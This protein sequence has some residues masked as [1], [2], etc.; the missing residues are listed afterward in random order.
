MFVRLFGFL[1]ASSNTKAPPLKKKTTAWWKSKWSI[2]QNKFFFDGN[3]F[4]IIMSIVLRHPRWFLFPA[5]LMYGL[6]VVVWKWQAISSQHFFCV[7]SVRAKHMINLDSIMK[8][9]WGYNENS[10]CISV[11]F[12]RE[13]KVQGNA[14]YLQS[15][16]LNR[17]GLLKPYMKSVWC[18]VWDLIKN[19]P[20]L[21][22]SL[23]SN[24]FIIFK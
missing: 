12:L 19:D 14:N 23:F 5:N 17:H 16:S 21:P 18:T 3:I 20:S 1:R 22:H 10:A 15:A 13:L 7:L 9:T 6:P 8:I 4:K 11:F 24:S 2:Q